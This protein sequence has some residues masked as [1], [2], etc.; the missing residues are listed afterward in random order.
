MDGMIGSV[1]L[2]A[3]DGMRTT[4]E[5]PPPAVPVR[6]PTR[7]RDDAAEARF[8]AMVNANFEFIWRSLRGLGV[9]PSSVDDAAQ[10]VFLVAAQKIAAIAEGSERAFLY[11]TARGIAS[12]ARRSR[13]RNREV[14]DAPALEAHP[15]AAPD[16]EQ[17]ASSN[18]ARAI[19][20]R[21]LE[22]MPDE[23]REVFVLYELEGMTT[24]AIAEMVG[25]PAG[26]AASRLRRA[27]E[28]FQA[29][30]ALVREREGGAR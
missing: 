24:A 2:P 21:I 4:P 11:A 17:M 30:A 8:R 27:R 9:P 10:Q 5:R 25:V 20:Q 7:A 12:N 6:A 14:E 18:R 1:A 22:D 19:L 3:P 28:V 29:A 23:L 15:D 26:T 13:A 16:P